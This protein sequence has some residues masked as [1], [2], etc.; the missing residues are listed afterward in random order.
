[1]LKHTFF[2]GQPIFTQLI[3][4]IPRSIISEVVRTN[5]SDR[6]CKRLKLLI[7]WCPCYILGFINALLF[8]KP[9]T[10]LQANNFRL[11]IIHNSYNVLICQ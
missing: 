4:F 1:M 5:A 7:T 11:H 2:T 3:K 6:Y 10:G 8:G 9:I